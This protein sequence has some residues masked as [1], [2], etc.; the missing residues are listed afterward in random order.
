[1]GDIHGCCKLLYRLLV[2]IEDDLS[3]TRPPEP[4]LF[5]FLGD[6]IDRGP[7]SRGVVQALLSMRAKPS[8]DARY[9]R[10][11]HEQAMLDFLDE[12]ENADVWLS[13]G[14]LE[15]LAS[16]GASLARAD[17]ADLMADEIREELRRRL[18]RKHEAFLRDT[19]LMVEVGDY[20]FVHA[21]IRPGIPLDAQ[22]ADDLIWIRDDFLRSKLP[23]ERVVVHGHTPAESPYFD[24][25]RI[26]VDTGAYL[27][28][29]LSAARLF[30]TEQSVI[31][32]KTVTSDTKRARFDAWRVRDGGG[33]AAARAETR[34]ATQ[35]DEAHG[36]SDRG[37]ECA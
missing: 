37:S 18:P 3:R 5:V 7:D 22:A 9:I 23:S 30:G 14:G 34:V 4:P 26:G 24:H 15:T 2:A 21:G 6:Y 27:T 36:A 11:N 1:V 16:Y 12:V 10:G 13:Y 20:G 25:R 32:A 17:P 35:S 33:A 19:V 8:I 31:Q 28:G 29:V